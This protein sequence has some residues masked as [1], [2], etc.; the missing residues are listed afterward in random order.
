MDFTLAEKF[1]GGLAMAAGAEAVNLDLISHV[2]LLFFALDDI[3]G[4]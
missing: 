3:S 2:T 4:L 1:L